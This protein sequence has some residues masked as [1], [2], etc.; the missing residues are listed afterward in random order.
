MA[1]LP[2]SRLPVRELF[3]EALAGLLQRPGRSLLTML[4]T[5]LG[6]GAFVAILGLTASAGGQIDKRFT[7]LA[8]TEVAVQ[9]VGSDEVPGLT[10]PM[11]FPPDASR[12]VEAINGVVHAGVFWPVPLDSPVLSAGP[13][14]DPSVRT[15]GLSLLAAAPDAIAAMHPVMR[16]GRV[17]DA[18]HNDRGERVA[19]LGAA[20]ADRL[21]ITRLDG[22]PAVFVD[23]TPYTVIGIV[24]DLRRRPEFLL[25]VI[26]PSTTALRS[27]GEPTER[28]AEMLV[29]TRVGAAQVVAGRTAVALRPDQPALF[30]VLAPPDPQTLRSGVRS[31]LGALFLVLAAVSLVIG[32]VG[33]ANTTLVAVLERTNE[34]GL[35]RSLGAR[36]VHIAAQFLTE[37]TALGL[38]GGLIG[39]SLGVAVVLC[40][41]LAQQ[42]TAVLAS[43]TVPA[44]PLAGALVGIAAGVYPALRAAWIEPVE[45]LRR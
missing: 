43:W 20:A 4:G 9:D 15:E 17:F 8:A 37:S 13:I 44:A 29:E 40:T 33:I 28:R 21:G 18:F 45:A 7:A 35:R 26:L 34:I 2:K 24:S 10:P 22:N 42:W 5:V 27:Y 30:K 11:S 6:I 3:G 39:G 14:T 12:R 16:S 38:L 31:D 32:A 41:A 25:S 1:E 36:P 23:G 19:V